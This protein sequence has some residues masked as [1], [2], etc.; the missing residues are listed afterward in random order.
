[1]ATRS[2]L[3]VS[4]QCNFFGGGIAVMAGKCAVTSRTH[5]VDVMSNSEGEPGVFD[6]RYKRWHQII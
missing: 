1:M 4:I 2:R 5:C 3:S 6:R